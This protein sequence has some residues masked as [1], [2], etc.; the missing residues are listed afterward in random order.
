[1][2]GCD[3]GTTQY[4]TETPQ[5]TTRSGYENGGMTKRMSSA[6]FPVIVSILLCNIC[7]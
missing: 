4:S 6:F 5:T 2:D 7:Q 3:E 1:M